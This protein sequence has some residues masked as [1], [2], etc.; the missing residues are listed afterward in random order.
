MGEWGGVAGSPQPAPMQNCCR[1][2]A[3][4]PHYS[5]PPPS[6]EIRQNPCLLTQKKKR[7]TRPMLPKGLRLSTPCVEQ[8]DSNSSLKRGRANEGLCS[9]KPGAHSWSVLETGCLVPSFSGWKSDVF[10]LWGNRSNSPWP[11]HAP[12]SL[13]CPSFKDLEII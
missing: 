9:L 11:C 5:S 10:W 3:K 6:F 1:R 7:L 8:S 12:S 13:G 2:G 4:A